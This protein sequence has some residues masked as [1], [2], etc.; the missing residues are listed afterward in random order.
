[1]QPACEQGISDFLSVVRNGHPQ[2]IHFT[3]ETDINLGPGNA[4]I[5]KVPSQHTWVSL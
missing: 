4:G 3:D 5:D 2:R 1:M